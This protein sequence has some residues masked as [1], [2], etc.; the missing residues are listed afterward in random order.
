MSSA[1]LVDQAEVKM[2]VGMKRALANSTIPSSS[3]YTVQTHRCGNND[4]G[5]KSQY[6]SK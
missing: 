5:A 4:V 2:A 1:P 3:D 6:Q